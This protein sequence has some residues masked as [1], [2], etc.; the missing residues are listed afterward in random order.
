[1]WLSFNFVRR[2]DE[3]ELET[4]LHKKTQTMMALF[5]LSLLPSTIQLGGVSPHNGLWH[6]QHTPFLVRSMSNIISD[7]LI[8]AAKNAW[9]SFDHCWKSSSLPENSFWASSVI[10]VDATRSPWSNLSSNSVEFMLNM[11]HCLLQCRRHCSSSGWSSTNAPPACHRWKPSAVNVQR[12]SWSTQL[13]HSWAFCSQFSP[14]TGPSVNSRSVN[15]RNSALAG[16]T[17]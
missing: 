6:R 1:M 9:V 16:R 13:V 7:S 5:V 14:R 8:T 2:L 4:C 10:G 3:S 11:R 15:P 17:A 12:I